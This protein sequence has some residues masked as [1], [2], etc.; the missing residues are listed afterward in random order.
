MPRLPSYSD[1]ADLSTTVTQ[2]GDNM[3]TVLFSAP[4]VYADNNKNLCPFAKL[5]FDMEREL[6][7]QCLKEA[8]RDIELAFDNATHDRLI[9]TMTRRCSCLHYSGHGHQQFL[10]FEDGSGGVNW[11]EVNKIKQLIA[12]EGGVP[13]RFVFVSACYSG[14]AGETFASAGVPHV[15]CCQQ[16]SELKDI[17][18]LAFTRQFYLALAVGH[19]VKESFE[20]GC[21]AVRATPNLK[22]AEREMQKFMLLPPDG[23][24]DVPIFNAKPV[25]EWPSMATNVRGNNK[26]TNRRSARNLFKGSGARSSELSVFNM[27]QED[28][29]P[30]APQ[31]F[32][33]RE[34][35]T[36]RVL[37]SILDKRL[38]NV[39]GEPGVGRSSLV[40]SLC[41]Y[42]NERKSTIIGIEK[43]YFVKVKQG[44]RRKDRFRIL[45]DRFTS[46]L[47][48]AE[49]ADP[50]MPGTDIETKLDTICKSLKNEKALV[51][52]DRV[53]LLEDPDD[54]NEFTML[55]SNLFRETR[56][57]KV[58]LTS[59]HPL[60]I[61]SLGGTV[62]YS[63]DLGPLTFANTVRLFA[64]LCPY[65]HTPSERKKLFERLATDS[66]E[67]ELLPTDPGLSEFTKTL[68]AIL[69]DGIPSRIEKAAYNVTKENYLAMLSGSFREE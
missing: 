21:K 2:P 57:V 15:V 1:I 36:Y 10:P 41:H 20:Q 47:V 39:V 32:L 51:V 11:F 19:T 48:E 31:F 22:N 18:A 17:A 55:L 26:I 6:I 8:S 9:A 27:M 66:A 28:P 49:K 42:I 53:H 46:K 58:L 13:F 37:K 5:D 12:N 3:I 25:V 7:W 63:Y 23:N 56:N 50:P 64:N 14:L 65:L 30:T 44:R 29:S 24:H 34:V 67:A 33:G 54:A 40:C 61:P 45:V 59:R 52:F 43:I 69:G 38:V 16:E 60:G 62:E 4:L 35:D 68:F